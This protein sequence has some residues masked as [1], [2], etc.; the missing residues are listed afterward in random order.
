MIGQER[1]NQINTFLCPASDCLDGTRFSRTL[2]KSGS[3]AIL[4]D[5]TIGSPKGESAYAA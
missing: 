5:W 4:D 3:Y 2:E 1:A